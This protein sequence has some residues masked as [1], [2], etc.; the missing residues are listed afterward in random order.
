MS[1]IYEA[2]KKTQS[3][4][5][6]SD[7]KTKNSANTNIKQVSSFDDHKKSNAWLWV[8][9]TLIGLGFV[10]CGIVLIL[11]LTAK[12]KTSTTPPSSLKQSASPAKFIFNAQTKT[13]PQNAKKSILTSSKTAAVSGTKSKNKDSFTLNG[14]FSTGEEQLALI[15]NKIYKV[16]DYVGQMRIV[17]I[18]TDKVELFYK[19][20]VTILKAQ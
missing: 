19:G 6:K 7:N 3:K 1:I 17:S 9:V 12:E 18:S 4:L 10:A 11:I 8:T 15:D 20:K 14:V 13:A 2:L 16:G 5:E